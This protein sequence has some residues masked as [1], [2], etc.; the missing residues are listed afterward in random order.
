[1]IDK[2]KLDDEWIAFDNDSDQISR[3]YAIAVHNRDTFKNETFDPYVAELD[4]EIRNDPARFG[5]KKLSEKAIQST[6][7]GDEQFIKYKLKLIDLDR[8]VNVATGQNTALARRGKALENLTKLVLRDYYYGEQ[9][10]L[11]DKYQEKLEEA[12][13][14]AAIS[15]DLNTSKAKLKLKKKGK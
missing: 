7:D 4:L 2:Y 15:K 14:E 12:K 10:I 13:R 11:T 5:I 8:E 6:I 3:D 9:S 1:M